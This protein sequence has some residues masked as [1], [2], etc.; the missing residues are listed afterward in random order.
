MDSDNLLPLNVNRETLQESKI[1]KVKSKKLV[2][3]AI[4]MLRKLAEKDE[5]KEGKDDDIDKKT[6]EV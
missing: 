4:E 1:V 3:K 5:S 2:S 6:K